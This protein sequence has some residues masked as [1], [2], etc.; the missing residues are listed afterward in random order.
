MKIQS[1]ILRVYYFLLQLYPS[2]FRRRFAQEML[3]VAAS[4]EPTEWPLIFVDTSI[5]IARCWLDSGEA[6]STVVPAASGAYLSLGGSALPTARIF[7]GFLLSIA[8]IL[9]LCYICS[10]LPVRPPCKEISTQ[11]IS[12]V[13]V[14]NSP[15]TG[16]AKQSR[17]KIG[18]R[19]PHPG[20]P[21]R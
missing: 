16:S 21:D 17:P 13:P 7:Q 11:L 18:H 20:K 8:I 12:A 19:A 15:R 10:R 6:T 1:C 3:E 4:S 5:G 2:A 9:G 14:R